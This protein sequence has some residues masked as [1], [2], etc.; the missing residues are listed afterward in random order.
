[1]SKDIYMPAWQI[2]NDFLANHHPEESLRYGR[3]R[4]GHVLFNLFK[5]GLIDRVQP[6]GSL[7]YSYKLK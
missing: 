1:M 4:V 2:T 6:K 7:N 5:D 3:E